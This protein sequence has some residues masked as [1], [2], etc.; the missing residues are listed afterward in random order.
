[1]YWQ[2]PRLRAPLLDASLRGFRFCG[3]A[4]YAGTSATGISANGATPLIGTSGTHQ[5]QREAKAVMGS[6][7]ASGHEIHIRT[8]TAADLPAIVDCSNLAF[9]AFGTDALDSDSDCVTDDAQLA[10][11]L[12]AQIIEGSIRLICNQTE[13]LGY[14]AFW[15]TADEMFVDTLAVSPKY[16]RRGL[17]SR[18]LAFADNETSRLGLKAIT[19]FTKAKMPGNLR[20]YR[21][22]GY[23]EIGRCDD[24][25]FCRVFYAKKISPLAVAGTPARAAR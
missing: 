16:H 24:D 19:L 6:A 13:I 21:R 18:L 10:K 2:S 8:A 23:R 5:E 17:G 1:M 11:T 20:F 15:P 22:R 9:A 12:H 4:A 25:G 3:E 7:I 14:I